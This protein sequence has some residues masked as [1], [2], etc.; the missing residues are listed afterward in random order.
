[1]RASLPPS[2][3]S[4]EAEGPALHPGPSVTFAP[5]T[6]AI[7]DASSSTRARRIEPQ[8]VA[9]ASCRARAAVGKEHVVEEAAAQGPAHLQQPR[10]PRW[11]QNAAVK[12]VRTQI[13]TQLNWITPNLTWPKLKP[14]FR[15]ALATWIV[16]VLLLIHPS[17]KTIGHSAFLMLVSSA[18]QPADAPWASIVERELA[19]LLLCTVAWAWSCIAIAIAHAVRTQKLPAGAA[20]TEAILRGDFIE[21]G[22]STVCAVFQAFGAAMYLWIKISFG[23]GPLFYGTV[24]SCLTLNIMLTQAP[25]YPHAHYLIGRQALVPLAIKAA[26]TMVVGMLFLPKSNNSLFCERINAVLKPLKAALE[27]QVDLLARSPLEADFPFD[28]VQRQIVKGESGLAPLQMSS[29]LLKREVTVGHASG[30]DLKDLE[31]IVRK[32]FP[33]FDGMAQYFATVHVDVMRAQN[34]SRPPTPLP[35]APNQ[36]QVSRSTTPELPSSEG[37]AAT[38]SEDTDGDDSE[39]QTGRASSATEAPCISR[40]S[41]ASA[42]HL[43]DLLHQVLHAHPRVARPRPRRLRKLHSSHSVARVRDRVG[44][45]VPVGTWEGLRYMAI[46]A[47]LHPASSNKYTE[48]AMFKLGESA[49]ELIELNAL[50][51][52]AL[53]RF[54]D[55][56]NLNRVKDFFQRFYAPRSPMR[57][58]KEWEQDLVQ[59]ADQLEDALTRFRD[60]KRLVVLEPLIASDGKFDPRLTPH[61]YTYQVFFYQFAL[62]DL[63]KQVLRLIRKAQRTCIERK[64]ARIWGPDTAYWRRFEAWIEVDDASD[65][66]E[67]E[68]KSSTYGA[69]QDGNYLFVGQ[70]AARDPDALAPDTTLEWA[71]QRLFAILAYIFTSTRLFAWKAGLATALV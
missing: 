9:D 37:P 59:I 68:L 51:L 45:S 22:P 47:H 46:D 13:K 38:S 64:V 2:L 14:V 35:L 36:G 26:I 25:L 8:Y 11:W 19:L 5:G 61:R 17:I 4:V 70:S 24:L 31:I 53:I 63:S 32:A 28:A 1:M 15:A 44:E 42:G 57:R 55:L 6:P 56:L 58:L 66:E 48:L 69:W 62:L 29:R 3:R 43:N 27:V 7:D 21:A 54:F 10:R 67:H 60:H 40:D 50:A 30:Q 52:G 20:T 12:A 71:G 39:L 16:M 41:H 34:P 65:Q 49:T 33:A 23:P 18:L